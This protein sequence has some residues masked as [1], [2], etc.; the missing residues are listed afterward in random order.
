MDRTRSL[1]TSLFLLVT[2]WS[3]A[4]PA[5]PVEPPVKCPKGDPAVYWKKGSKTFFPQES[6][7]FHK[8]EG[9]GASSF[10]CRSKALK[11]GARPAPAASK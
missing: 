5:D 6:R 9:D 8:H 10:A 3:A 2:V 4:A 11:K 1:A 7:E